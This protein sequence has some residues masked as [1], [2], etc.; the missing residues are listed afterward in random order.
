VRGI[1]FREDSEGTERGFSFRKESGVRERVWIEK[2]ERKEEK[3]KEMKGK[4]EK[5]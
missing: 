5:R 2:R 4:R 1:R 3:K